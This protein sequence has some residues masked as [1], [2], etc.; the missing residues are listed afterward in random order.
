MD[1]PDCSQ[2]PVLRR[3][4]VENVTDEPG[5]RRETMATVE[6]HE[7]D[8]QPGQECPVCKRRK[9]YPKTADSPASVVKS[10]RLPADAA[11]DF[12]ADFA[13]ACLI[14]GL[15]SRHKFPI[16]KFLEFVM[17]AILSEEERWA[18]TYLRGEI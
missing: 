13:R 8:V 2:V 4:V 5:F 7:I 6:P 1:H 3:N 9:P 17:D 12:A 16:Y 14:V 11:E 15:T 10:F 18:G